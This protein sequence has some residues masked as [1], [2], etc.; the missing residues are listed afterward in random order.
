MKQN[1]YHHQTAKFISAVAQSMPEMSADVMQG[2]I[3]NP[4]GLREVLANTLCPPKQVPEFV[5]WKTVVLGTGL[6]T[7]NDFRGTLDN[8]RYHLSEWAEILLEQPAF[9]VTVSKTEIEIDLVVLSVAELGFT[10]DRATYVDVCGQAQE[11][12]LEFCPPEVGPQLR[13][14]YP[15]QS[16]GEQLV[17]GMELIIFPSGTCDVFV[18][19]NENGNRCLNGFYGDSPSSPVSW[20]RHTR[21]VFVLPRK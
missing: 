8:E 19:A 21:L 12:G 11:L 1:T 5:V 18:V 16:R 3:E 20:N 13:R 2:W 9:T 15:D 7:A 6:K 14:Q 17:I 10:T 4:K